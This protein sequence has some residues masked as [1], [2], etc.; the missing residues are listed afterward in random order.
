MQNVVNIQTN[1]VV[2]K[3]KM[4]VNKKSY[5]LIVLC[6]LV[7]LAVAV[8]A[9]TE[10]PSEDE[11]NVMVKNAINDYF[12]SPSE[13]KLAELQD[14]LRFY[15]TNDFSVCLEE[16]PPA[17][18]VEEEGEILTVGLNQT[19]TEE[20]TGLIVEADKKLARKAIDF[21]KSLTVLNPYNQ[22]IFDEEIS[23]AESEFA[24]AET[25]VAIGG[26][27]DGAEHFKIAWQHAQEA[28]RIANEPPSEG[29]NCGIVS[30]SCDGVTVFKMADLDN[31]HAQLSGSYP[32]TICC[33]G[34]P[35]LGIENSG[36]VVL[37]FAKND[38]SHVQKRGIGTYPYKAYLSAPNGITCDYVKNSGDGYPI[39]KN[40]GYETCLASMQDSDN[41]H[42]GDCNAYSIKVCCKARI[43][44]PN[45]LSCSMI[46]G[47]CDD[48]SVFK[49][50]NLDNSH[51]QLEGSYPYTV[52]CKGVP[53]LGVENSG[54]VVLG[55]A[56]EDDAHVQKNSINT[57]PSK[58]YLS[59]PTSITCDYVEGSGDG[60]VICDIADYDTC[61]ASIQN[62]D[63]SHIGDCNA[64]NTKVCCKT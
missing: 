22:G 7:L 59:A 6:L 54:T 55:F 13:E 44:K 19:G 40:A 16:V 60:Y 3:K 49:V 2:V 26:F 17:E 24:E 39:C 50:Q 58:A 28:I 9:S 8:L 31:S 48:V 43:V 52:C 62:D 53:D 56:R 41:S 45:R 11:Y 5:G 33:S 12:T 10:C 14:M 57:Y 15:A 21:A 47:S 34:I 46:S 32:Y 61:L 4:K 38:D 63:N 42:I 35:D 51:A 27:D 36:T 1:V 20:A 37:G 30:E 23:I 29:L 25:Y 18:G 64:Y